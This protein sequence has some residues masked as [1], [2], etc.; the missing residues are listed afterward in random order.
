MTSC[1]GGTPRRDSLLL[2]PSRVIWLSIFGNRMLDEIDSDLQD[3]DVA[4]FEMPQFQMQFA[5]SHGELLFKGLKKSNIPP[6]PTELVSPF[7][8]SWPKSLA[9]AFCCKNLLLK[10]LLKG[11][12][13]AHLNLGK[14]CYFVS[15]SGCSYN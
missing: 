11:C 2:W 13:K 3:S 1:L 10:V 8:G 6:G 7:F 12:L 5:L 14:E 9:L 15:V 4:V